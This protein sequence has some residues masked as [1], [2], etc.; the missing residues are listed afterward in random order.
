MNHRRVA[1]HAEDNIFSFA[2]ERTAKE[3]Q[4]PFG[5]IALFVFRPL[6]EKQKK[7][8]LCVLRASNERS[9]WAVK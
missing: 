7:I 1:K 9:E 4:C 3:K 5:R 2:V 6:S 8:I